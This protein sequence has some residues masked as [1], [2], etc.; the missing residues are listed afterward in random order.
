MGGRRVARA[1]D[2]AGGGLLELGDACAE[3]VRCCFDEYDLRLAD[4]VAL[5]DCYRLRLAQLE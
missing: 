4:A 1:L 2:A 3:C 5:A